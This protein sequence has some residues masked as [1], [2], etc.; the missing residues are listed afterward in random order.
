MNNKKIVSRLLMGVLG[1]GV[2]AGAASGDPSSEVEPSLVWEVLYRTKELSGVTKS[3]YLSPSDIDVSPDGSMLY[4]A[5]HTARRVDFVPAEMNAE[6]AS[7]VYLPKEPSGLAVSP[8][9]SLLY[10]TCS[11]DMR[12]EGIVCVINTATGALVK[13]FPAGHSAR[14]PVVSPDGSVLYVC[15]RFLH[16]VGVYNTATGQKT[17]EIGVQREPYAARLTPDG[18]RLVVVN[19]LPYG[20]SNVSIHQAVISVIN[21]AT[22]QNEANIKLTNGA[23]SVMDIC[24]SPDGRYAYATHVRSNFT[25]TPLFPITGGWINANGFSVVDIQQKKLINAVLLDDGQYGGAS[26]P[27]A[28]DCSDDYLVITTAGSH[29]IHVIDRSAMHDAF[30]EVGTI[31]VEDVVDDLTFSQKFTQ[32]TRLYTRGARSVVL[33]GD[34]A[35]VS[36]YF[37]ETVDM[38][39]V[40]TGTARPA[41]QIRLYAGDEPAPK[42]AVRGGEESFCDSYDFLRANWHSCHSCHP[43]A[44]SDAFKWDLENDG[45]G[46]HK[47]D[48]SLLYSHITPPSMITGVRDYAETATR[49]GVELILFIEPP[50][51][52]HHAVNIDEYLKSLRAVP[53]PYLDKGRLSESAQRGKRVFYRLNCHECH[54][55]ET[56]FTDMKIHAGETGV[57]DIG[58]HDGNW[59]TPTLHEVWRTAPYYHDGRTTDMKDLY[60]PPVSHGINAPVSDAELDDL[61]EYVKSL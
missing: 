59:D 42:D 25:Q 1:A 4:I 18:S 26:N 39:N 35:F 31:S 56:Y 52:E 37:S 23:Q 43:F 22:K 51:V 19:F 30:A 32:R 3:P 5:E 17:A 38:W 41:G 53:S 57:D 48:K 55:P 7:S 6:I 24:V 10:V 20:P 11:S 45:Q 9:G 12:P 14:S 49:K 47:N 60:K 54:P 8:D 33:V 46:N 61:V 21:T 58:P 40:G 50:S 44:R 2:L 28:I 27:W 13:Q 34:T 15:N 29:E 16:Y 36:G